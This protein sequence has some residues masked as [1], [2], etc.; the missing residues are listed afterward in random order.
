MAVYSTNQNRQFYVVTS[1]TDSEPSA[2]GELMI[3]V[4]KDSKQVFFKHFGNGGLT[5]TDIIDVDK[6]CY[7]KITEKE[8]L[9]RK[10]KTATISLDPNV[11]GGNPIVGQD[12]IVRIYIHNY[13]APG[14]G[15]TA[16]K[17]GAVHAYAGLT[18]EDFYK[19]MAESLTMNFSREVQPLL[20]FE[21]T[22][23]GVTMT[24][25]EQPWVL[26]MLAQESVNFEVVPTTVR[27]QGDE[28]PWAAEV[29]YE[30][31][32]T[33]IGDGRKIADLEYF[34][35]GERAD[36]YR[37]NVCGPLR[38][39]TKRM[40]DPTKE[41][42]VLDLH[43]SFSD[44]GVNVQKSEKDLTFVAEDKSVLMEITDKLEELGVTIQE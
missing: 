3:G 21:A 13:L 22:S 27:Y 30:E 36:Q 28:V 17:H 14:D 15:H 18:A 24:E 4:T 23:D 32:D 1:V 6:L 34:C 16:I 2:L 11:N 26:G 35:M 7:A 5:R 44:T 10:L 39:P 12:Y 41:Y 31:S 19:K 25:V 42:D 43:Y 20:T 33:V 9:Q 40:V 8:Q 29:E 37:D 38:I